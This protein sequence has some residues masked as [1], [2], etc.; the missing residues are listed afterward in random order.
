MSGSKS[1]GGGTKRIQV[2]ETHTCGT[3]LVWSVY[4][5]TLVCKT[6]NE[7][8][9]T[10]VEFTDVTFGP[11]LRHKS[12]G[13]HGNPV[14]CMDCGGW[15]I[16]KVSLEQTV[17]EFVKDKKCAV[18]GVTGRLRYTGE[19]GKYKKIIERANTDDRVRFAPLQLA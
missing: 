1:K 16:F 12:Y 9:R 2:T 10:N 19:S 11:R 5:K 7:V 14:Y 15:T 17:E 13:S 18:C 6:C 3:K 8:V 4:F